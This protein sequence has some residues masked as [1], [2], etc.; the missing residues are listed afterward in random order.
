MTSELLENEINDEKAIYPSIFDEPFYFESD[1]LA[2]KGN[3]DY[4]CLLKTLVL[5]EAQRIKACND[6]ENL[7]EMKE[8]A[9]KEPMK[10]IN[11]LNKK[12]ED[13]TYIDQEFKLPNRQSIY[14]L[15]KID[16]NKYYDYIDLNSEEMIKNENLFQNFHSL[17]RAKRAI[18]NESPA[19]GTRVS[20]RQPR[21]TSDKT[22]N[23]SWNVEE[24]RTLEELL[25]EFPPEDN[26][27]A[28]WR[29]IATKL[30]TRSPLQVQS[31]CQKYFI[32]L[33]KAGLPVP[34]RM[35]NLKTYVTKKG[36]RGC[37]KGP[38]ASVARGSGI[39]N[40]SHSHHKRMIGRGSTL[41]EISSMWSSFNPPIKMND[42]H[43]IDD[44]DDEYEY[45]DEDENFNSEDMS[46]QFEDYEED[47]SL[48]QAE[49]EFDFQY[50]S[51]KEE[52]I[53]GSDN[54]FCNNNNNNNKI[55][56]VNKG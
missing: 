19:C 2:L 54:D 40:S 35:P 37:R 5:L 3:P 23:K 50:I 13:K 52:P 17:R 11:Y 6:L 32:K 46:Q 39:I 48:S 34:G 43:E 4:S 21:Q 7:L 42:D 15:P 24:Q 18:Q 25:I 9:L 28:R 16:W 36:S 38:V 12:H 55:G 14:M 8:K 31:H 51:P 27:A 44:D 29:K 56:Q 45:D 47:E 10:F 33:A 30:G 49:N 20:T 26:E 1:S 22:Y 53:Y 41:N